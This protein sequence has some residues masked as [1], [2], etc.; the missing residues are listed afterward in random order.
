[1]L[2]KLYLIEEYSPEL[3]FE[4]DSIVVAL[5]PKV[6]Y[7]FDKKG[8]KY[9]IIE[10]YYDLTYLSNLE[11]ENYDS[12][13]EAVGKLDS[14]LQ[15]NI[16]D[17]KKYN[18]NLGQMYFRHLETMLDPVF[19]RSYTLDKLLSK[20]KPSNVVF[21]SI[22]HEKDVFDYQL[23]FKGES[24]YS[25]LIPI[26]CNK[27]KITFKRINVKNERRDTDK[28]KTDIKYTLKTIL[29]DNK[30][31]KQ[32]HFFFKYGRKTIFSNNKKQK[33]LNVL[34]LKLSHI[35]NKF[36]V[37][38]LKNKYNTYLLEND[39]ILKC[40]PFGLKK[41]L[42]LNDFSK[43][44]DDNDE[45]DTRWQQIVESLDKTDFVRRFNERCEMDVSD[46]ILPRLR[47]FILEICPK[48]LRFHLLNLIK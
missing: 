1:M 40:S 39:S 33:K 16:N 35:E 24:L 38:A 23:F 30:T 9:S 41:Y 36:V 32:I 13:A 29:R 48:L 26:I 19:I 10:D 6:C 18:L 4:K 14:H 5:T 27:K 34:M 2:M 12:L 15:N 3:E 25:R 37:D 11:H 28:E 43:N 21:V 31:V 44:L 45:T 7:D 17:L 22:P 8:I 42:D 46:I 47:Y 20:I